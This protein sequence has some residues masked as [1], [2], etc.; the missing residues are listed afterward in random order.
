MIVCDRGRMFESAAFHNWVQDMGSTVHYITPEMHRENG[1]AERYCRTVLNM[2]RV[3]VRSKGTKWSDALWKVQLV[4]N[5]TKHATTQTS[6]LQLL[7]GI[8]AA[9]PVIRSL[10]RDVALENTSPNREALL[11]LRRQRASELLIANQQRQDAYVNERR[12]QPHKYAV[13]DFVFVSKTSQS[14]GKLDSGMRGPYKVLRALAHHRYEL[15]LLAGS[16]G[17]KTQAA[18]EHMVLW[19]GEWTPET[20]EAFFEGDDNHGAE[21]GEEPGEGQPQAAP[22]GSEIQLPADQGCD[23]QPL[24]G[25]SCVDQS[26]GVGEATLRSEE[27]VAD[28]EQAAVEDAASSGT[29]V[30]EMASTT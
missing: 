27:A 19:R 15:E 28:A 23:D 5:I 18:A 16:Y 26:S 6:A 11:S 21:D 24:A 17:K 8:E 30:L 3:E 2:L 14:T 7:V 10:I 13:G 22:Q 4:L 9:T 12:R 29:A 25:P 20:C 1:Q